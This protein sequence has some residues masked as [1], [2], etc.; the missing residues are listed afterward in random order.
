MKTSNIVKR[1][2]LGAM[3]LV[4]GYVYT[5]LPAQVPIH[6]NISGTP[7]RRSDKSIAVSL[8]PLIVVALIICFPLLKKLDPKK[9]Q[10]KKFE[11][12]REILQVGIVAFF[13][14]AYFVSLYVI[15]HPEVHIGKYI[16]IGLGVLFI[17]L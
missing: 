7:N 16:L 15:F 13:A 11:K 1:T 10:Y 6:R 17:L 8:F 4:G 9:E 2:L 14:Y 5:Q 12:P 3:I